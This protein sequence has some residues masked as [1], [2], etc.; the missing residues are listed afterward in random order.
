MVNNSEH[1]SYQFINLINLETSLF[2]NFNLNN[3]Y[4]K[5]YEEYNLK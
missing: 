5:L 3:L 4:N 1:N 2:V